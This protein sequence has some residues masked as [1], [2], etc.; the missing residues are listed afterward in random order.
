MRVSL[1]VGRDPTCFHVRSI[2]AAPKCGLER[3]YYD[4]SHRWDGTNCFVS[5]MPQSDRY[6]NNKR[7][8]KNDGNH[9]LIRFKEKPSD[10]LSLDGSHLFNSLTSKDDLSNLDVRHRKDYD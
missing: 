8:K 10:T 1:L 9:F 5:L 6:T 4:A 7:D 3:G 2:F